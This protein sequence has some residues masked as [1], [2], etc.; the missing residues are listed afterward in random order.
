MTQDWSRLNDKRIEVPIQRTVLTPKYCCVCSSSNETTVIPEEARLQ[1][2]IK[3][4]IHIPAGNRCCLIHLIQNRF[5]EECLSRSKVYF[6]I[7][8]LELEYSM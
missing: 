7:L 4:R 2:F 1:S 6:P 5:Y 3:M 8:Q